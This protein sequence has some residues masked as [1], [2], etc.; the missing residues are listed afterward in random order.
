MNARHRISNRQI[1][2]GMSTVLAS[3]GWA[4]GS[5]EGT[6]CKHVEGLGWYL[7]GGRGPR[8]S[9]LSSH[10]ESCSQAIL[11]PGEIVLQGSLFVV[12]VV[13]HSLC[14]GAHVV[15]SFVN[16]HKI[17]SIRKPSQLTFDVGE[18]TQKLT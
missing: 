8:A 1:R 13:S 16:P 15:L 11:V 5:K 4:V 14:R 6:G 3:S 2:R 17:G 12:F 18:H 9:R 10:A 7:I